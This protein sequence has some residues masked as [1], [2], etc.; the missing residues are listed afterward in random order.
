MATKFQGLGCCDLAVAWIDQSA[1]SAVQSPLIP[2]IV[3]SSHRLDS[4]SRSSSFSQSQA[5][6]PSTLRNV[7]PIVVQSS[8]FTKYRSVWRIKELLCAKAVVVLRITEQG[9]KVMKAT[10]WNSE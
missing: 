8:V 6:H 1:E 7:P 4:S 5:H 2:T 9:R 10:G 3:V